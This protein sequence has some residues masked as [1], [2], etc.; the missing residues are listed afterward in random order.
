MKYCWRADCHDTRS[1]QSSLALMQHFTGRYFRLGAPSNGAHLYLQQL[2]DM[3]ASPTRL[4]L[5]DCF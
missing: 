3:R 5:R 4:R 1:N 2:G